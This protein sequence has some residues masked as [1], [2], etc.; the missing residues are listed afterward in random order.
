MGRARTAETS[1]LPPGII[2][3]RRAA[4]NYYYYQTSSVGEKRREYPLGKVRSVAI[5][6]WR[7]IAS[8]MPPATRSVG[9]RPWVAIGLCRTFKANAKKRGIEFCLTLED[10]NALIEK[11]GGRCAV[12][13]IKFDLFKD[14]G[15]RVRPWAPSIDRIDCKMGYT[16]G[17]V[18]LVANSV[19]I[20]L[21][22]FGEEVLLRIAKGLV[23]M[24]YG[25]VI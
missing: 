19:N 8:E 9:L 6:K 17:N 12:T 2:V 5:S 21:S 1:D 23:K 25:K 7:A 15:I 16:A 18:R 11:S 13:G 10:V 3:R 22:D 4:G 14:H 24:R 20:A